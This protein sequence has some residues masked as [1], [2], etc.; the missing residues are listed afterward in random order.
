MGGGAVQD[1]GGWSSPE[2][3]PGVVSCRYMQ[4]CLQTLTISESAQAAPKLGP[5]KIILPKLHVRLM[6]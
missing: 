4:T 6:S 2:R 3:D 1:G 5:V